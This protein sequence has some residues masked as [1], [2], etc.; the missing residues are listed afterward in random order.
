MT[1]RTCKQCGTTLNDT[2]KFCTN[3]GT[4][5]ATGT[6]TKQP[7]QQR[8]RTSPPKKDPMP[9]ARFAVI[10]FF[11]AIV[12]ILILIFIRFLTIEEHGVI[13]GQPVVGDGRNYEN[14][15]VEMVEVGSEVRDGHL[16]FSLDDV[17]QHELVQVEYRGETAIVPVLAYI[18]PKGKLVTA[19][20]ISEPCNATHFTIIGNT[21]KCNNCSANWD[22]NT[23]QAYA[24]CPNNPPDP[25]PSQT[26]GNEVR[27]AIATL[28]NWRRRL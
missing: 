17:L 7:I 14:R 27:V 2:A 20:S 9:K 26:V 15:T 8:D 24:C 4:P 28:E 12:V 5:V 22:L 25:I 13:A 1:S 6:E 21:I 19:I 11:G 23:M 10:G 16:V 3:C 18:S